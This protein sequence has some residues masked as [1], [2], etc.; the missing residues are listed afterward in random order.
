MSI[1]RMIKITKVNPLVL[2]LGIALFFIALY[3]IAKGLFTV[4][5]Y[6][7]PIFLIGALVLNY[8]VVLGYGKWLWASLMRNPLFGIVAV[9]LSVLGISFVSLFLFV[10]A[11]S[12]RSGEGKY[13][14]TKMQGDYIKYEEVEEDFLDLS[15][16]QEAKKS[17]D[18]DYNDVFK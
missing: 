1:E 16:L 6:L 18:D 14:S 13:K 12:S 8:R 10:R 3:W 11:L 7:T 4:L 5:S 2:L 9:V 17:L 15:E